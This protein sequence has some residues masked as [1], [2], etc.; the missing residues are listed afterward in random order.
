MTMK[1]VF[2][3]KCTLGSGFGYYDGSTNW[4][5]QLYKAKQFESYPEAEAFLRHAI[6]VNGW[7]GFIQIE[8]Y[9]TD[10]K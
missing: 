4:S 10:A 7:S 9:F 2:V 6:E 8:K 3:L 1:T 5:E